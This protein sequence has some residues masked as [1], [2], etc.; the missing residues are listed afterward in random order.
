MTQHAWAMVGWGFLLLVNA[1]PARTAEEAVF[2]G[3][4]R[5]SIGIVKLKQTGGAVT[6]SYGNAGQF[7]LKGTIKGKTLTFAYQEGQVSGDAPPA[8]SCKRSTPSAPN[9]TARPRKR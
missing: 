3:E 4:W 1:A 9:T 8:R 7:N 2:D 5:T 6:G